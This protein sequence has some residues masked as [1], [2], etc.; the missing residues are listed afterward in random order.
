[1]LDETTKVTSVYHLPTH[2]RC[3]LQIIPALEKKS[4]LTKRCVICWESGK[5]KESKYHCK[6]CTNIPGLLQ[7]SL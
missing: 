1:M 6:V 4:T 2:G 5:C 7:F 3:F